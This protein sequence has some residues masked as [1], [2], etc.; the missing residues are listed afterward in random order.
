MN[1]N[2]A[3]IGG[4]LTGLTCGYKLLKKGHKVTIFE[5]EKEVGG[6]ASSFLLSETYLEK[7]YHHIFETDRDFLDLIKELGLEDR[8]LWRES[9]ISVYRDKKLFPFS[10]AF[11]LLTFRPIPLVD[12]IRTGLITLF[13][14]RYKNWQRLKDISAYDWMSKYAG[15]NVTRVIW[16]PLLKGKFGEAYKDISMSWLWARIHIRANSRK[17]LGSKEV[18]GYIDGG[19]QIFIKKLIEEIIKKGGKIMTESNI[20]DIEIKSGGKISLRDKEREYIYDKIIITGPSPILRELFSSKEV[21]KEKVQ[22][23]LNKVE[24]IK[25]LGAICLVFTSKQDLSQYYWHNVNEDNAPF[26]V[27]INHTKLIDKRRYF[28][29]H[30]YYIAKYL[31]VEDPLYTKSKKEISKLWFSYLREMFSAFDENQILQKYLFKSLYAQHI[32]DKDYYNIVPRTN[33]IIDNIYLSNFSL[34]YPEDRGVNYAV[35]EGKRIADAIL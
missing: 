14:Q 35:K 19:F 3:I 17:K 32:V 31:S 11:D 7:F 16:E 9:S 29:N 18:L 23:Y 12:R 22:Y 27:F 21:K 4:G 8:L 26:L 20:S 34:I 5:K 2:I 33:K 10:S 15:K 24:R 25:Y 6:L 30:V 1:K 13:L 28:G